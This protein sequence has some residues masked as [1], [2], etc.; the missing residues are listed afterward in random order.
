MFS[1]DPAKLEMKS[2]AFRGTQKK[3]LSH[4]NLHEIQPKAQAL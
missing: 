3:I 1:L 4:R 2:S